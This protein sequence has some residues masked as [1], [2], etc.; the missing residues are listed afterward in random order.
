MVKIKNTEYFKKSSE[1]IVE[2]VTQ[3]TQ[4]SNTLNVSSN[5][6][7][8]FSKEICEQ[9]KNIVVPR[10][11][12]LSSKL[13]QSVK[14]A[15]E[16][17][18][19]IGFKGLA[20]DMIGLYR[21][22]INKRFT[23]SFVGEFSRGKSTLINRILGKKVLPVSDLPT[24]ALL[25]RIVYGD[26]PRLTVLGNNGEKIN[27]LPIC[28]DSWSGLTADN[29]GDN[30]PEG[31]VV[32]E[33]PDRWLGKFAIDFID[34]PGAGDLKEKRAIVIERTMVNAD[35]AI[36]VIDATKALSRTEE[37]FIRQKI[38]SR[39]VPFVALAITKLD[40]VPV[41]ERVDVI[42]FL[43][44][45]LSTLK[46]FIPIIVADDTIEIPNLERIENA[47]I[48]IGIENLKSLVVAWMANENRRALMEKWLSIN[49]LSIIN[50]ARA[51]LLQQ[52]KIIDA[53]NKEKEKLINE[54]N[55]A[56]SRVHSNWEVLRTEMGKRCQICNDAFNKAAS[57][58]G[59]VIIETLQ[60]EADKQINPKEWLEKDYSYRVKREL[61]AISLSLDN[62]VTKY[63]AKDMNWLN[64]ELNKQFK[65]IV[66]VEVTTL[67]SKE[68]FLPNVNNQTIELKNLKDKNLKATVVSSVATL[69]T[70]LMLGVSGGAPLI[71]AT[72]GV[73]TLTN[74][75]SKKSLDRECE[76][77]R[78]KLKELIAQEIPIV[79]S[80][81]SSSSSTKIKI[82]YND[83][84]AESHKTEAR[85]MMAQRD[86]IRN[87]FVNQ[88]KDFK[89]ELS[90]KLETLEL[91]V[92]NFE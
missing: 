6:T 64:S 34:T 57:E 59:N 82:I 56:L 76:L 44:K 22:A 10:T 2:S 91:L 62:L 24:T 17:L 54:R 27:E 78:E 77:Q 89:K 53:E 58:A 50:S 25:T 14:Q 40:L 8:D 13:L 29:F 63:V 28:L 12:Q 84:I 73:G 38:M 32:V 81:A 20:N 72:M 92:K 36:I 4:V 15:G 66:G 41:D 49:A 79:I 67:M 74:I 86:L 33:Y 61:S 85:W 70:A 7:Q 68:Y 3:S 35:A 5:K 83:I 90:N 37:L 55:N 46:I 18:K 21:I 23:V 26:E 60:H 9:N 43:L 71:F 39:G 47:N 69:G 80:D 88:D 30:E 31:S 52:K 1:L 87:S 51:F 45:R 48:K 11:V 19:D 75:L 65:E 42:S 16:I